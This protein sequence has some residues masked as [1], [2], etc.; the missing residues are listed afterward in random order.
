MT[1]KTGASPSLA[2]LRRRERQIMEILLELGE[3]TAEEVRKRLP[4]PPSYSTARALLARLEEKG[5]VRHTER[6]LRY[7]YSP[8]I[9]LTQARKS[10]VSRLVDVFFEG[11][12]AQAVTGMVDLGESDLSREELDALAERIAEA[13]KRRGR[14]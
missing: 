14:R 7:V 8:A 1:R 12:V 4:S 9:S 2:Q 10:A 5:A 11:S 6:D 3:A 13:R